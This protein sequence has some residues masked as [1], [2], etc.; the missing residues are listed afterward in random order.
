MDPIPAHVLQE[1]EFF[2]TYLEENGKAWH[3]YYNASAPPP[4][5]AHALPLRGPP[6]MHMWNATEIGQTHNIFTQQGY[7]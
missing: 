7:W 6:S 2:Q 3:H 5:L 1:E 4:G